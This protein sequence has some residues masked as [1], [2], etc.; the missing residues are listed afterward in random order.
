MSAHNS[1]CSDGLVQ[2]PINACD[3][4]LDWA[5][6]YCIGRHFLTLHLI[7]GALYA[8]TGLGI[9]YSHK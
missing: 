9:I 7:N 6:S 8:E 1:I 4:F 3:K 5:V 2:G